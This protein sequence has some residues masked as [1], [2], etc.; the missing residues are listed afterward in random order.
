MSV[1]A[2]RSHPVRFS[3]GQVYRPDPPVLPATAQP[4]PGRIGTYGRI[5]RPHER[6]AVR[7]DLCDD[8][9]WRRDDGQSTASNRDGTTVSSNEQSERRAGWIENFARSRNQPAEGSGSESGQIVLFATL[10]KMTAKIRGNLPLTELLSVLAMHAAQAVSAEIALIR[11]FDPEQ[12]KLAVQGFYGI[13]PHLLGGVLGERTSATDA[14]RDLRPGTLITLTPDRPLVLQHGSTLVASEM[15][16]LRQLGAQHMLIMP[17]HHRGELL[18]RLDLLRLHDEAFTIGDGAIANVLGTLIAG[19][20]YGPIQD[21]NVER[22]DRIIEASFAFQQSIAPLAN[23]GEMLQSIVEAARR[24]VPCD[25]CYGLL[26]NEAQHS[27]SPAAV[28]GAE[29]EMVNRLK[30]LSLSTDT[31]P[32]LALIHDDDQVLQVTEANRAVLLPPFLT[33]ALG[34]GRLLIA[35]LHGRHD[36]LIGALMLECTDDDCEFTARDLAVL[37]IIRAHAAM[38]IENALLYEEV[39]QSSN[40]LALVNDIGIELATLTDLASLFDQVHEQVASVISA[41]R[42]CLGLV[43]PDGKTVEYRYAVDERLAERPVTR[44]LGDDPLSQVIADRRPLLLTSRPPFDTTTWFPPEPGLA[45]SESMVAAAIQ[46]G[47]QVIGVISAQSET[48]GA[49]TRHDRDL[50]ATIGLQLGV[51]IENARLYAMVHARGERRAYLL[52]Q[53]INRQEAERKTIADDIHNDTLQTLASCLYSIDLISRRA[54]HLT[55]EQTQRE[56]CGVRDNLAENIDRLRHIIFQIRPSTLDILGLEPALREH[57]KYIEGESDIAITLDVDLP[58]RLTSDAETAVYR[59]VQETVHHT[60]TRPGVTQVVIR[61]RQ[62]AETIIV[63]IADNGEPLTLDP[64][65]DTPTDEAELTDTE[66]QLVTLKERVELNGG[67]VQTAS[68]KR[69]GATVQ[70]ILPFRSQP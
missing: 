11:V 4:T 32:A 37:S 17:L 50:L 25:R 1:Q 57:A 33:D 39:T 58:E 23:V 15:Q 5:D 61:V 70:I 46:V 44:P 30:L 27:F 63:T 18:G 12:A 34:L 13:A 22:Y 20:I 36:N 48:R 49:Y 64:L 19:A 55:P 62:K 43:L 51:A 52:D 26:W 53:M 29:P 59:I 47:H 69:G 2:L 3:A 45:Q 28:S 42:F 54:T 31:I 7:Y 21:T 9:G 40:R 14:F 35:P 8:T 65:S 6:Q 67:R 38:M 41:S 24:A 10:Q 16:E 68:L 66:L 60:R 56:L